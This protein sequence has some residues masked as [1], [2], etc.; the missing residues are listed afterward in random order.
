MKKRAFATALFAAIAVI[1]GVS[2]LLSSCSEASSTDITAYSLEYYIVLPEYMGITLDDES[3][4][5]T[6]EDVAEA[7]DE[8]IEE[9]TGTAKLS[10]G[11]ALIEGDVINMNYT[12]Y[13][14][15][16]YED[17]SDGDV[18]SKCTW[19][20]G[21]EL[22]LGSGSFIDGFEDA[23]IGCAVGDTVDIYIDFPE[24]FTDS[25]QL[26]GVSTHFV[27][28]VNSATRDYAPEY[29]DEFIATYTE[30]STVEEYE[31]AV[32]EE[33]RAEADETELARYYYDI[34]TYLK[35][36]STVLSYPEAVVEAYVEELMENIEE[37][38]GVT[39]EEYL[40]LSGMT[41]SEL[42]AELTAE[43]EESLLEKMIFYRI[44]ELEE[45]TVTEEEYEQGLEK[46]A[47]A[48]GYS[49]A[50]DFE[51]S[52]GVALAT[53]IILSYKILGI[54]YGAASIAG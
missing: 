4:E 24:D 49:D 16:D 46:Y 18:F 12:G 54:I 30:Y 37:T 45:V 26:A 25:P 40:T 9:H 3:I 27:V 51:D 22:T 13:I 20:S 38:Y 6:D 41:E 32:Y 14:V 11:Q 29:N 36:N 44:A 2:S 28:T 42:E 48:Y 31:A 34:L 52:A 15:G 47:S 50:D 7:A 19:S 33:L 17:Y 43:A 23:L 1:T 5:V 8:L 39:I 35:S 21:Y 10:D 53:E